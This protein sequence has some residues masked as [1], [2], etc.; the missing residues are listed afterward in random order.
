[1]RLQEKHTFA[2]RR[3]ARL[4]SYY[5][6]EIMGVNGPWSLRFPA[7]GFLLVALGVLAEGASLLSGNHCATGHGSVQ[8]AQSRGRLDASAACFAAVTGLLAHHGVC[9]LHSKKE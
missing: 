3:F 9:A 8:V 2:D 4:I 6:L 5:E 7:C 1:M